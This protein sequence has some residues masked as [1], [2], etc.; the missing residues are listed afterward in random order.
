MLR[1]FGHRLR[2]DLLVEHQV[3]FRDLGLA[4]QVEAVGWWCRKVFTPERW[5]QWVFTPPVD[6]AAASF[7]ELVE[8]E[9]VLEPLMVSGER[10]RHREEWHRL[11]MELAARRAA[12]V[13]RVTPDE[14]AVVST[15]LDGMVM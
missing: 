2:G 14:A 5:T 12:N 10:D 9:Q 4:E 7:D 11:Q 3:R 1:R 6:V 15:D 8:W 13:R